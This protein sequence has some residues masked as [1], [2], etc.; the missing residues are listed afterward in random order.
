VD[1]LT[2]SMVRLGADPAHLET[3]ARAIAVSVLANTLF[4][5]LV[6]LL[7]G[8]PS[9]RRVAAAGLSAFAVAIGVGLWLASL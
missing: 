3:A 1:A 2:V 7:V 5:L 8:S 4:K 9:F 6:A